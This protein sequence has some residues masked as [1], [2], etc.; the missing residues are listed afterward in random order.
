MMK[1]LTIG[2]LFSTLL[3]VVA[4]YFFLAEMFSDKR[5]FVVIVSLLG[6]VLASL[7]F[8]YFFA[9]YRKALKDS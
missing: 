4:E 8:I 7:S 3:L 6:I 9:R 2:F 5:V 1:K